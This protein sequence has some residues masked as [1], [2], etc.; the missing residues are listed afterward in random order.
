MYKKK[1]PAPG[2][3]VFS[4]IVMILTILVD[5]HLKPISAIY[6]SNLTSGF[7]GEYFQ[8]NSHIDV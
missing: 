4:D 2:G 5:S 6:Q 7:G 1:W 3:H 8:K